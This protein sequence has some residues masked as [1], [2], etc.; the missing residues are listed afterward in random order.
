MHVE[1]S[2]TFDT[3][4]YNMYATG[5]SNRLTQGLGHSRDG[6]NLGIIS[7][8]LDMSSR[9]T[10]CPTIL[11][12]RADGDRKEVLVKSLNKIN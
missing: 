12:K 4:C 11:E 7:K 3:S 6:L 9:V 2:I 5:Y 10:S 1:N 8:E